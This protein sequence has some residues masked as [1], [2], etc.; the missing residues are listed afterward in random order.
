MAARNVPVG[1]VEFS[2][3]GWIAPVAN[4]PEAAR[5]AP[6]D[7]Q[8]IAKESGEFLFKFVLALFCE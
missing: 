3:V 1:R 8:S 7:P 4:R 2:V 5:L 6:A